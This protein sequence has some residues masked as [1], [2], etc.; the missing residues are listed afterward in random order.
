MYSVNS[1]QQKYPEAD[2]Y[3]DAFRWGSPYLS[4]NITN[5]S[6]NILFLTLL[7]TEVLKIEPINE[8][9]VRAPQIANAEKRPTL[10]LVNEG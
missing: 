5:P 1:R 10:T 3:Y 2:P 9:I 6:S 4:F 7:K 8:V